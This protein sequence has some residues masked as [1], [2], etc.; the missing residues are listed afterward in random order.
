MLFKLL[1][2]DHLGH[3]LFIDQL[4]MTAIRDGYL[5]RLKDSWGV[6]AFEGDSYLEIFFPVLS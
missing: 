5:D 4:N 2:R 6:Q 1:E 3:I